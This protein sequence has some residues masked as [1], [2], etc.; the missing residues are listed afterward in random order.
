LLWVSLAVAAAVAGAATLSLALRDGAGRA[1]EVPVLVVPGYNGTPA[2]V[3]PLA[4]RIRR[5]G[6]PVEAL[7]LPERGRGDIVASARVLAD[8]VAATGAGAVDLV[9]FSAGGVVVRAY[10]DE[11]DEPGRVRR[12]VLLGAPNH[13]AEVAEVAAGVDPSLCTGACAQL[14]PG[15]SLLAELNAGDE[16]PYPAVYTNVWTE[17]DSV[18][19]PATSALLEGANN[20]SVQR[21]CPGAS[22]DHWGLVTDPL[23][24]GLVVEALRGE[25]ARAG[26]PSCA[27][28][29]ALGREESLPR[30]Q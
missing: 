10:L 23:S 30:K 18:V 15:S 14:T 24:L 17:L 22:V 28:T 29:R 16:T 3:A 9:G 27:A 4:R 25:I 8:A 19:T 21:V 13:G 5:D 11:L 7:A 20:V 12:V 6:R 26:P 2:S 1:N